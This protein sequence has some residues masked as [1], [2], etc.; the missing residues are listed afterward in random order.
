MFS[1]RL[2][3]VYEHFNNK[4]PSSYIKKELDSFLISIQVQRLS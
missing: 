2:E 4:I 3:A 1:K